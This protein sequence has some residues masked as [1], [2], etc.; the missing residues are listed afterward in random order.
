MTEIQESWIGDW[1]NFNGSFT[2]HPQPCPWNG[3]A[4]T[5]PQE[6]VSC[7]T[8]CKRSQLLLD[9]TTPNLVTCGQW[10]FL[11]NA[12]TSTPSSAETDRSF[13]DALKPFE[14]VGLDIP[15]ISSAT[16]HISDKSRIPDV[17]EV[18]AAAK[19]LVVADLIST[20]LT[21]LYQISQEYGSVSAEG[22][23]PAACTTSQLFTNRYASGGY[24]V[25]TVE[26]V[27]KPMTSSLGSC[28]NAICSPVTADLDL[29]GIGVRDGFIIR[30]GSLC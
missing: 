23:V 22:S 26:E 30:N 4:F 17:D 14:I 28:V 7:S 6:V 12:W 8:A 29:A 15:N 19:G 20:C 21:G 27:L 13:T 3:P 18:P 9:V 10:S 2:D 11:I 1:I 25:S 24:K 5:G 16:S